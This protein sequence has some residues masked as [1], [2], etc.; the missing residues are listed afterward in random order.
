[1]RA[2]RTIRLFDALKA[3]YDALLASDYKTVAKVLDVVLTQHPNEPN[4]LLLAAMLGAERGRR[5]MPNGEPID[6]LSL[7]DEWVARAIDQADAPWPL[8]WNFK[9]TL[10][11]K[12][13]RLEDSLKAADHAISLG[14]QYH[15]PWVNRGNTLMALGRYDEAASSFGEAGKIKP[16]HPSHRFNRSFL[17][18]VAGDWRTGFDEY[19]ARWGMQEW[20][21]DH[22]RPIHSTHP[23]WWGEP[24][25]GK[26]LFL[27]WEQGYGDSIMMLR[28]LPWVRSR[29]PGHIVLE[30]QKAL[31]SLCAD[32]LDTT[33][34][35]ILGPGMDAPPCDLW[36]PL[37]GLPA[38]HKTTRETVPDGQWLRRV[39]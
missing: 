8:A 2:A 32:R 6:G 7:A 29:G 39:A 25:E 3:G 1:M 20:N 16:G 4:G 12:L 9:A 30:V 21:R 11:F 13:G 24:L 14:G 23:R 5:T 22:G 34:L 26:R 18:L 19:E 38:L 17:K 15:E 28:Y 31:M 27:H 33:E 37:F 35:T 36:C 10:Y